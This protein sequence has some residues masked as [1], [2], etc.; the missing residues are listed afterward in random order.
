MR[1][2]IAVFALLVFGSIAPGWA[3]LGPGGPPPPSGGPAAKHLTLQYDQQM[4]PV[5]VYRG[6]L[7]GGPYGKVNATPVNGAACNPVVAGKVCYT[8]PSALPGI[9]EFYVLTTVASDGTESAWSNQGTGVIPSLPSAPS[10]FGV[11]L[12]AIVKVGKAIFA[13]LKH[14]GGI[15]G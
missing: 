4:A 10:G 12:A 7:S 14:F 1:I 11:L 3:Q 6:I 8:D 15:F 13:G 2:L 5:N 9:Q